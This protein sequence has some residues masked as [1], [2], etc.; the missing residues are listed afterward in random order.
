MITTILKELYLRDLK[1]LETEILAYTDKKDLWKVPG[2][3]SNSAGNLAL[4]I[5]GNLQHFIGAVLGKSGYVRN[6]DA[7]FSRKDVAVEELI[8]EIR[9]TEAVIDTTLNQ[10]ND[11]DLKPVFPLQVQNSEMTIKM[12]E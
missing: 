5:T 1:K 9:Q 6:R 12:N 2:G 7:E 8:R 10:M 4:H 3:I 11:E